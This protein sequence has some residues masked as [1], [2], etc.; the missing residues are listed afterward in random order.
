[1]PEL[2]HRL[3]KNI[4]TIFSGRNLLYHLLAIVLTII[5]VETGF[6]W[7]CYGWTRAG[8]IAELA[9]PDIMLG[10]LVPVV[11]T[12]TILAL[13]ALK[14]CFDEGLRNLKSGF[15]PRH[16]RHRFLVFLEC[17]P[18]GI[19]VGSGPNAIF[20]ASRRQP[21]LARNRNQA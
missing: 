10:T 14:P 20:F 17:I 7:A 2:F 16:S 21:A 8:L 15:E 11:G 1:M 12:F 19:I 13:G 6:D 4:I 9:L 5:I 18:L 3:P